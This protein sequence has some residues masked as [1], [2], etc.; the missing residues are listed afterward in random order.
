MNLDKNTE[1]I[2]LQ[3]IDLTII[4][5]KEKIFDLLK[6]VISYGMNMMIG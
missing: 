4:F 5:K 1:N 6:K 2:V 3:S